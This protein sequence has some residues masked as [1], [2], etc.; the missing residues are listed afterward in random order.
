MIDFTTKSLA[1]LWMLDE[2]MELLSEHSGELTIK[3]ENFRLSL[4]S[5]QKEIAAFID[6]E[7]VLK[8]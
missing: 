3:E 4:K 8:H 1:T 2:L 7:L 5:F 6:M